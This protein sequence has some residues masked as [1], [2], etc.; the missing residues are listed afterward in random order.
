MII[1]K[2]F[3]NNAILAKDLDKH[4]FVDMGSGVGFIKSVGEKIDES[5]IIKGFSLTN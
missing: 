5:L 1:K 4:E 3:N 2:I